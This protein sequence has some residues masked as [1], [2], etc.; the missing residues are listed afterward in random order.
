[1]M[2]RGAAAA[3]VSPCPLARQNPALFSAA[4]EEYGEIV[5]LAVE[6]AVSGTDRRT[7]SRVRDLARR[8]AEQDAIP[9]DLIAVHL[10]ALV[11][12]VQNKPHAMAKACT[13]HSR[14][15]LVKMLG[16]L[17]LYYREQARSARV[18]AP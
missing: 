5:Q 18:L 7:F 4:V 9:Q 15:L 14:V 13:R 6:E 3:Q 1:M 17:A 10:S 2:E 12:L 11:T 8:T 16:E